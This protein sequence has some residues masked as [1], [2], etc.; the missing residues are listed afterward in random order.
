ML[1][2][3]GAGAFLIVVAAACGGGDI[4][5]AEYVEELNSIVDRAA[6]QYEELV[7]S[8]QGAV[9]V[10]EGEQ[11]TDFSPQDLSAALAEVRAIEI[12]VEEATSA[13]EPPEE[14]TDLHTFFFDLDGAFIISQEALAARA[15]IVTDWEELS[16]SAEMADYRA[17]L[18]ADKQACTRTQAELKRG[19]A[20]G[21]VRHRCLARRRPERGHRGGARVLRLSRVPG[22]RI[23][24]PAP[25]HRSLV[26]ADI[27][28]QRQ[29]GHAGQSLAR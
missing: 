23:P 24:V 17:A 5:Q 22:G 18:A 20:N 25:Y 16:A 11:L 1:R 19:G 7:S 8:P 21:R 15:G 12:E 28:P 2:A 6:S 3:V 4:S 27:D 9:L 14:L 10:A 29:T 26:P 13:I